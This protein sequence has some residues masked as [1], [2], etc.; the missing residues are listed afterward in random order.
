MPTT[1]TPVACV[2]TLRVCLIA[3]LA[4]LTL[5][6]APLAFAERADRDKPINFEAASVKID[7]ASQAQVLTG[8]VVI[9]KGTLVVRADRIEI[10]Q[11]AATGYEFAI[12]TVEKGKKVSYRQKRDTPKGAPEEFFEGFADAMS[13]DGKTDVVKLVGNAKVRRMRDAAV[14][15]EAEGSLIVIENLTSTY[16]ITGGTAPTAANPKGRV[17]GMF[18]PRAAAS[19]A[20]AAAKPA[21]P[22]NLKGSPKLGGSN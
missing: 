12:A 10:R 1:K 19:S 18:A 14:N 8:D 2:K 4:F 21:D 22:V 3:A 6:T 11:D 5:G 15:D 9:T 16:T 20:E 7:E 13:Y 17:Q